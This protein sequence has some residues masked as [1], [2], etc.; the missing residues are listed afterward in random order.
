MIEVLVVLAALGLLIGV[1][2]LLD[3]HRKKGGKEDASW[4]IPHHIPEELFAL[5]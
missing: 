4:M 2:H 1:A 5:Q 3:R